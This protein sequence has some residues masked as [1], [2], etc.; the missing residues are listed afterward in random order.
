MM[1]CPADGQNLPTILITSDSYGVTKNVS[2]MTASDTRDDDHLQNIDDGCGCAEV[3]E[4]MSEH[5]DA[6]A[7]D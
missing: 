1:E 7:D 2:N 3:W 6:Q 4:A 5:R